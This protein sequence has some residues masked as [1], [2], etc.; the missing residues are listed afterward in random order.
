MV[1]VAHI[2]DTHLGFRQYNLDER[3]HDLY[4]VMDEIAERI[5][6]ERVDIVIHSGDL[7]D[8]P[9]PPAQAYY[10]FKR[11]LTRIEG[12]V[13][14]FSVLGDHDT[15]KR[16]GMPPQ[17]LF[18]D[19][20]RIL[21]LTGGDHQVL[22]LNGRDVLIA[23]VSHFSRR[24][25][26]MLMEELKKLDALAANYQ[27]SLIALH[28]AVDRFLPFEEVFEL[29]L[30][31]LPRNFKYYA[32][33]H[34]HSRTRASFGRGELAYSGSTEIMRS[35]EIS[36][37]EKRGKGFYIVDL[38]SDDLNIREV[39]LERLRPQMEAKIKYDVFDLD[40]RRLTESLKAYSG[41]KAPILHIIVEGK[42][43]DRQ[44]VQQSLN[45]A[46]LGKILYFRSKIIEEPERNFIELKPG[47]INIAVLLREYL[48]DER[49]AEFGY[50]LFKVLKDGDVEEAKKIADEYFRRMMKADSE[51]G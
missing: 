1:R 13:K 25:R 23:G 27:V 17:K 29:R 46:L 6:E 19:E 8:S 20:I 10:V 40:L 33:G 5:L 38:D 30:D 15:P 28:Q 44:R 42:D 4:D 3:E 12:K 45:K 21:G 2:A 35:D 39:N 41:R 37:W 7:F 50:E 24:Y 43:I 31:D 16:R 51:K 22:R 36:D 49:A 26:E 14:F 18:D 9:R 34:L 11:F 47:D 32:M 48:K